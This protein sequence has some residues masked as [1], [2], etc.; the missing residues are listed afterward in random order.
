M[1]DLMPA[2]LSTKWSHCTDRAGEPTK[3]ASNSDGGLS[4]ATSTTTAFSADG[5][6]EQYR[7]PDERFR[8]PRRP[9]SLTACTTV[10]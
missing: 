1:Y 2:Q 6:F 3:S 8:S 5:G 7:T 10:Q 9:C 4:V